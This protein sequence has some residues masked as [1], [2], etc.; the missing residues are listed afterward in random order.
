MKKLILSFFLLITGYQLLV[1][2]AYATIYNPVLNNKEIQTDAPK[3][4]INNVLSAIVTM[5]FIVAVIYF[6]WHGVFAGLHLIASEGE[7]KKYEEAKYELTWSF[8]G[9]VIIFGIFAVLK[10]VGT[11]FGIKGLDTLQIQWPSI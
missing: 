4:Y 2:P 7:S 1:T 9:L 10:V 5:F 8:T 6:L 11:I 3:T